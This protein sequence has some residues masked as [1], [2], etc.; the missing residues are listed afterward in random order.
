MLP[1]LLSGYLFLLIFRPYEY[2]TILGDL[3]IERVYM[4]IFMAAVFFSREKRFVPSPINGTVLL[5]T[6]AILFSGFFALSWDASWLLISDYL[7]FVIFYFMVILSI[8]NEKDFQFVLLAF[9]GVMFLYVGKSAWEFFV[10][11]RYVWR[12]GIRRMTGIDVTYGD[13]NAF[14]ASICYS[15]PFVWAMIRSKLE[16]AWLRRGLWAYGGLAV[17][18]IVY[19]GSR[20]GMVTFILFLL[21]L[22]MGTSRKMLGTLLIGLAVLVG[23]DYVPQDLQGRFLSVVSSDYEVGGA[24][25][26]AEGRTEGFKQGIKLFKNSPVFGIGPANFP[27]GWPE[28]RG[29][30]AHNVYGQLLGELGLVGAICFGLLLLFMYRTNKKIIV[31]FKAFAQAKRL[32]DEREAE[33]NDAPLPALADTRGQNPPPSAQPAEEEDGGKK[34]PSGP[35][36]LAFHA[37]VAQAVIQTMV[38]MLF[39]GWADH[40]LYRYTWLW[41]AALTV[42]GYH[43]FQQEAA[44]HEEA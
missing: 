1:M 11:D 16:N 10:H 18:A 7:K 35:W 21:L 27:L 25:T 13:P 19:T 40:N 41:L 30:N 12:M 44:R 5:F 26:S 29:H 38:L 33:T 34:A 22:L 24:V 23:W 28:G 20:S 9:L 43:F 2:W 4:L 39:K 37:F 42:L 8:R 32:R 14:A 15:L 6:L 31:G 3:R 36:F 17:V